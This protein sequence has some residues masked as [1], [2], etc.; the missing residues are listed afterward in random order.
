MSASHEPTPAPS[1]LLALVCL[2]VVHRL[3]PAWVAR[4]LSDAA[5]EEKVSA[6][7]LSRL[8][9]RAVGPFEL[10]LGALTRRGRPALDRDERQ[11]A[12]ELAIVRALLGCARE[13]LAFV[14][15]RRA[16]VRALFV[17]AWLRVHQA[18][19]TLSRERFCEAMALSP[20]TLRHWLTAAPPEPRRPAAAPTEAPRQSKPRSRPPRRARFGFD[21]VLPGAQFATDTTDIAVFGVFGVFRFQKLGV[22]DVGGRDQDLLD[23][24]IVDPTENSDLV[25]KLIEQACSESPGA[26]VLTDQG[27][28]YMAKDTVEKLLALEL[29]H[30][31]QKEGD[32]IGKA[33]V[34]RAFGIVKTILQP[35]LDLTNDLAR[36]I[37]SLATPELAQAATTVLVATFLRAYQAGARATRRAHDARGA[38][39]PDHLAAAAREQRELARAHD[40]SSRLILDRVH[41]A[42]DLPG[43][44]TTFVN[45]H[46]RYSPAVLLEAETRFATQVHRDDIRDRKSYFAAIVRKVAA[47][48][49]RTRVRE[50]LLREQDERRDREERHYQAQQDHYRAHPLDWLRDALGLL[51]DEWVPT[52]RKLL[53]HGKGP[54]HLWTRLAVHRLVELHGPVL[55]R[56]LVDA[57]TR[58]FARLQADRLGRDGVHAVLDAA[59]PLLDVIPTPQPTLDCAASFASA[60]LR[61][62]GPPARPAPHKPLRT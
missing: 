60:M 20:R 47:E 50:E 34:E 7:R 56:D 12:S 9:S 14:P 13:L 4:A 3:R 29:E 48:H 42:Y 5:A 24:V 22:Q 28:P 38:I 49:R 2:A 8:C 17:G 26:Q 23:A 39:D 57:T 31:P 52:A 37:P 6:Q 27:T 33:T 46:R 58:D 41:G 53:L 21:V 43:A 35:L 16:D 40:R 15:R 54:G 36:R 25:T 10:A 19:P 1:P 45:Q 11:L 44:A 18:A 59:R 32:P 30:S 55:A 62:T 61:G 51:A